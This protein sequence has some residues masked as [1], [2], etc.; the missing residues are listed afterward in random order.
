[1]PPQAT[2][3]SAVRLAEI[4]ASLRTLITAGGLASLTPTVTNTSVGAASCTLLAPF[5]YAPLASSMRDT[6]LG[7]AM[8]TL[9]ATFS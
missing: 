6:E 3:A 5:Y 2:P 7:P 4:S 8:H 9:R 1:M